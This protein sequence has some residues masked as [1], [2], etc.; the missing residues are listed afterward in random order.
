MFPGRHPMC[1]AACAR[2]LGA[3]GAAALVPA[4]LIALLAAL[5][6]TP[7]LTAVRAEAPPEPTPEEK[8][9]ARLRDFLVGPDRTPATRRDAAAGLMEKDTPEARAILAEVLTAPSPPAL[10]V[11]HVV[12]ARE[13]ADE[14]FI[15]P[16]FTYLRSPDE[17]VRRAA[18]L[19]FGTYQGHDKVLDGLKEIV[20]DES[21]AQ[22]VRL[23]AVQALAQIIDRR[24]VAAL[25]EATADPDA[26]VAG[27][28][29]LALT[30][31]TGRRDFGV[32]SERWQAWWAEHREEPEATFLRSLVRRFR[33]ELRQRETRLE[34]TKTR[35][36]RLLA[37]IYQ[38]CDP[39]AKDQLIQSHLDDPLPQV[40][41]MAARQA[42]P[43]GREVVA[44]NNG[45][46][47]EY[48]DLI[49]TLKNRLLD[50][51][52]QVR[53]AA[54][55]A[56]AAWQEAAA[57]PA[58]VARLEA[59]KVPE[60]RAAF[61]AA[62][63]TLKVMDAVPN[64]VA[65]LDARNPGEVIRAAGALGTLG[66]R[67]GAGATA[68]EPAFE[69]LTRLAR[70]AADST[71]REAAVRALARIAHP[72]AEEVLGAALEDG[73]AGVRFSATQ[74]LGN[75]GSVSPKA[76][77]ALAERLRDDNKSVRQAAAAALAQ[78]DG[79]EAAYKIADRL[80]QGAEPEAGVR[81]ALWAAVERLVAK[82]EGPDL[83]RAL[84]DRFFALESPE[85]RQRA[86]AL[87]EEALAKHAP[88]DAASDKVRELREKLVDAYVR[89]G[90]S[91]RAVPALRQ[92][93]EAT[94]AE[95]VDRIRRLKEQLGR[96]LLDREPYLDGVTL[97]A[98]AMEGRPEAERAPLLKAVQT[99]AETLLKADEPQAALAVLDTLAV[100]DE[101]WDRGPGAPLPALRDKARAATIDRA[102]DRLN[103]SG[104]RAASALATL[105]TL[106]GP[107]V[108]AML[109]A[110][111]TAARGEDPES[112]TRLLGALE[113]VTERT[114]H[115][116]DPTTPLEARLEAL[117][118]WR[119]SL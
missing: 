20:L 45:G 101:A 52:P 4:G 14:A 88:A 117:E 91:E 112:E 29:A 95:A 8:E 57:G 78:V 17:S 23:A 89:A 50:E 48:E 85:Q 87:Y 66:D 9:L 36:A 71:V 94:P 43:L 81:T 40:R 107:A 113:S 59:E 42:I 37:E 83:A 86:A 26:A 119:Q 97:L 68:V 114:D 33:G 27:A 41:V 74:G 56:L 84:G 69:P 73:A 24:S 3:I 93:L 5:F 35:L 54:A 76:V 12:A 79:P 6:L 96:I 22:E 16:I 118:A 32:S 60:V 13:S 80:K 15:D 82:S 92:L 77:E 105:K 116:Y 53:A 51:S 106:G 19:A 67:N 98:D 65:M 25:V 75:L 28:A 30:D 2:R 10:A 58:L 18:A 100:A 109:T 110:L 7:L 49:A 31:M 70:Q 1:D 90:T 111:E 38:V 72:S 64:L 99:R 39:K 115:G 55:E 104:D 44:A 47:A 62:L 46:R 21:A 102:I 34:E 108:R 63:G 11:L 103:G 61:A